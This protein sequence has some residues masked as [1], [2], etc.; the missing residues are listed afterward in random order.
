[1][2]IWLP[3]DMVSDKEEVTYDDQL[4]KAEA[5]AT[6]SKKTARC[7]VA[8]MHMAKPNKKDVCTEKNQKMIWSMTLTAAVGLLRRHYR[9]IMER[10]SVSIDSDAI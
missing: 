10:A 4:T 5:C 2:M 3:W 9:L 8:I 1:M 7:L 6:S